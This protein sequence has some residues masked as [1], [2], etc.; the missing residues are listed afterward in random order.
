MQRKPLT[1]PLKF[2]ASEEK[3]NTQGEVL[4]EYYQI[5]PLH[6]DM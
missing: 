2:Q 5:D 1:I 3:R 6:E 4:N